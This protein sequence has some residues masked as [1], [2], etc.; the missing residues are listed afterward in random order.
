MAISVAN[1][2]GEDD[3]TNDLFINDLGD[4]SKYIGQQVWSKLEIKVIYYSEVNCR[5]VVD[6]LLLHLKEILLT[7]THF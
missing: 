4:Q 5:K 1:P 6:A 7:K 3:E 2:V